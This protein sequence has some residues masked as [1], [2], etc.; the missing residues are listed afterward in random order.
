MDV[1]MG[2]GVYSPTCAILRQQGVDTASRSTRGT[3]TIERQAGGER[4][5]Q[6]VAP[7]HRDVNLTFIKQSFS[8]GPE[9]KVP[10]C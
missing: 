8:A 6:R 2:E 10:D 4:G 7:G 9:R 5:R 3:R 1:T